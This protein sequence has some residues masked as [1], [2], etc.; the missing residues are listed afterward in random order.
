MESDNSKG[1]PVRSIE[2]LLLE[3]WQ[4]VFR[5]AYGF[6]VG[7]VVARWRGVDISRWEW[8][9]MFL[10][11]LVLLRLVP[12]IGRK[13]LPFSK[14]AKAAWFDQRQLAKRYDSYQ[15]AKL[16]WIGIG[17]GGYAVY[18]GRLRA[19]EGTLALACILAGGLGTVMWL[20][21]QAE[22]RRVVP[23]AGA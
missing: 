11:A 10:G 16:L 5:I 4:S 15:W 9:L 2:K 12:I 20:R 21:A 17:I 22:V 6:S 18:A 1:A 13:V 19:H 3:P 8:V 14:A 23:V 7:L